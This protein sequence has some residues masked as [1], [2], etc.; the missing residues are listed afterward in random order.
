MN[1]K[2]FQYGPKI[3]LVPHLQYVLSTVQFKATLAYL[4]IIMNTN[5]LNDFK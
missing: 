3:I 1:P 2:S 4:I 5:N